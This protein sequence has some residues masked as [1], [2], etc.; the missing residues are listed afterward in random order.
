MV[1]IG[2]LTWTAKVEGAGNAQRKADNVADSME[3]ADEKAN[4]LNSRLGQTSG[5]LSTGAKKTRRLGTRMTS[6]TGILGL[7]TSGLFFL[8][9]TAS[10]AWAAIGG[11]SGI[12]ATLTGWISTA[13]GLAS[14][15]VSWLA[16]GS[17][18]ALAF[19][20][21]LGAA[22]GLFVV[23]ILHITGVM[24]WVRRLGAMIGT[25]LPAWARDG[26]L[27]LIGIFAGPLAVIGG[28]IN[29]FIEGTMK[30]GLVQ[31]IETGVARATQV[32]DTFAGAVDRTM[33]RARSFVVDG[34]SGL[35]DMAATQLKG[36][37]NAVVPNQLNIPQITIG[38]GSIAGR[39]L[40]SAT[41][42]GGSIDLPQ[43]ATGGVI[44]RTGIIMGHAGERVLNTAEVS[45]TGEA[46]GPSPMGGGG[47]VSIGEIRVEFGDQTLDLTNLT[48]ADKEEIARLVA[49]ETGREVEATIGGGL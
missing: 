28:F 46:G 42:G 48:Q 29:G 32:F 2:S 18:G 20:A 12:V 17:A 41:I 15:F 6:L 24:D 39:D 37:F 3:K 44:E 19:A 38:G 31:G 4:G 27:A 22:V 43:L 25:S 16:A 40:P 11:L 26:L 47:G 23:W 10:S 9:G 49:E 36:G 1:T 13:A 35:G 7:V 45:R 21:A 14:G 33:E 30:G 34:L 5:R 8:A